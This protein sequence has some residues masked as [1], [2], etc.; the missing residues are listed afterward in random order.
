MAELQMSESLRTENQLSE[1]AFPKKLITY[2]R[3]FALAVPPIG[4]LA[5]AQTLLRPYVRRRLRLS[6]NRL[7]SEVVVTRGGVGGTQRLSDEKTKKLSQK[8]KV[9]LQK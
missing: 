8:C 9:T 2:L 6:C 3:E 4:G 5:A 7:G 1:Q